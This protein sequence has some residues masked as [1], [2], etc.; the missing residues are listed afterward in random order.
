M[1]SS[2][3]AEWMLRR[4]TRRDHAVSI[5]GDLMETRSEKGLVWFWLATI[6]TVLSLGWRRATGFV[7]SYMVGAL[8][9]KALWNVS[10]GSHAVVHP[11]GYVAL[12]M[13]AATDLWLLL[14]YVAFRYGM[15]DRFTQITL[16][17]SCPVATMVYFWWNPWVVAACSGLLAAVAVASVLS[18]ERLRAAF[19]LV[20]VLVI[21][22]VVGVVAIAVD[23]GYA[24]LVGSH[25]TVDSDQSTHPS[26]LLVEFVVYVGIVWSVTSAGVALHQRWLEGP[27]AGAGQGQPSL[28]E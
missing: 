19:S 6:G 26:V 11:S 9:F 12:L 15:R 22:R 3:V 21:G 24:W 16:A 5:V 14:G 17:V 20:T 1:L 8:V 27:V 7:A 18:P 25:W 2:A 10:S 13:G 28:P 4:C 23:T